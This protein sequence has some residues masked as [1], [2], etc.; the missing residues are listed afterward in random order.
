MQSTPRLH[1][2]DRLPELSIAGGDT[3]ISHASRSFFGSAR[4]SEEGPKRN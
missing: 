1:R 3:A 4:A 2:F